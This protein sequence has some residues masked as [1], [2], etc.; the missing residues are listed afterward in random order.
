MQVS[1]LERVRNMFNRKSLRQYYNK[2]VEGALKIQNLDQGM[3]ILKKTEKKHRLRYW[4]HKLRAQTKADRREQHI[5]SRCDWLDL[6]RNN[7]NLKDCI[8]TWRENVRKLK[9]ARKFMQRAVNGLQRNAVGEA[10]KKWKN[11]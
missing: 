6:C 1:K 5:N 2:W 4:L 10:F 9:L 11:V 7:G 8:A 3:T